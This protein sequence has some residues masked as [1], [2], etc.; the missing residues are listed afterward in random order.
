MVASTGSPAAPP[1]PSLLP[2]FSVVF[3]GTLGFS[4]VLPFLVFLVL[5]FG[6]NA[7][8]YGLVGATYSAFQLV[9]API[10]G[11]WSDRFGRRRLLIL[12]QAGTLC[13]WLLFLVALLVPLTPILDI[14]IS[15]VGRFTLTVPLLVLFL[16][17]A[18]DG[19]TGGNV[20][21]A[22][23]YVADLTTDAD[24]SASF[25]RLSVAQNLGFVVGP[26]IA[27]VLGSTSR[28][29]VLPVLAAIVISVVALVVIVRRLP[30]SRTTAWV[31]HTSPKSVGRVLGQE[32]RHCHEVQGPARLKLGDVLR[33]PTVGSL[34]VIQFLVYLAFNFFYVAFPVHAA[35]TLA[36]PV[37]RVGLFLSVLSLFMVLVQ[38]PVLSRVSKRVSDRGLVAV[39]GGI[40]AASFLMFTQTPVLL[41]VVGAAL[42][43]L[44]NGLMWPSLQAILSKA[45]G[46]DAQGSVQGI[47]S[48]SAAVASIV[49]LLVGGVLYG[50]LGVTVFLMAAG[51]VVLAWVMALAPSSRAPVAL[52]PSAR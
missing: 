38:G 35:T 13:A 36:W 48:S 11:R 23:A 33:L 3:I 26:A 6:G 27:G 1:I 20:A 52:D 34:L 14:D 19:L 12:T 46:A 24:R 4:L 18:L 16:A 50:R 39:G 49:G 43:A 41:L 15:V 37:R 9:G 29:A 2:L 45:A 25:G 7:V 44:G 30:E 47:A 17:R 31:E 5:D 22:T 10:I 32:P 8:V 42:L 21:V 28:G 40:L 51:T